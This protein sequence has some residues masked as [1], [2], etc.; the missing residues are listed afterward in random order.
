MPAL[1]LT[2]SQ[3]QAVMVAAA[4]LDPDKRSTMQDPAVR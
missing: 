2:D 4:P 3:V 1:A